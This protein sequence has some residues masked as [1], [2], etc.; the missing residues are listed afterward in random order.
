MSSNEYMAGFVI[1]IKGADYFVVSGHSE[2][3]CVVRGRFRVKSGAGSGLPVV[4]DHVEFRRGTGPDSRGPTGLITAILPRKSVFARSASSGKAR[5]RVFCANLDFV[6]LVMSVREPELNFRLLDRL[7]VAA[8]CGRMEPVICVNKMDLAGE[9]GTTHRVM[10]RYVDMGYRVILCSAHDGANISGMKD[11]M[12][13][14]KSIMVGPS[15]TGKTSIVSAIQP[16][17]ELRIGLVSR[18]TGKGRHTTTHLELHP[19]DTG[20]YLGDTPGIREFGI[21]GVTRLTLGRSFR[22][23]DRFL[24]GCRFATCTH[25]HEPACA[26][27][28]AVEHNEISPDRYE[29]YLR[30]LE[31]LPDK[32]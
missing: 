29:S 28:D 26:V 9:S 16:G 1:R 2:V 14:K 8:E 5:C 19:L 13:G 22:D 23:F 31:T 15:G 32:V 21:W 11:L 27:K 18:K 6:F 20:G 17:L 3:R 25:S 12:A 30:I 10:A 7:L 24:G 4:G